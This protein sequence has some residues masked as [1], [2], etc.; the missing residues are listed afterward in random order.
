MLEV[1][2]GDASNAQ[3]TLQP[4]NYNPHPWDPFVIP[5][6]TPVITAILRWVEENSQPRAYFHLFLGDYTLEKHPDW[7]K[8]FR[9]W[10]AD[11]FLNLVPRW[12]PTSCVRFHINLWLM[13]GVPPASGKEQ[14]VTVTRFEM[15]AL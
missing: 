2:R 4:W 10:S 8:A 12:T 14:S 5:P 3:F 9:N 6:N 15:S 11:S 7:D 1:L 13:H